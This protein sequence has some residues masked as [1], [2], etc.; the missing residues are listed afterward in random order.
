MGLRFEEDKPPDCRYCYFWK[1][2]K[3]CCS[4][5][6]EEHCYYLLPEEDQVNKETMGTDWEQLYKR[7]VDVRISGIFYHGDRRHLLCIG[8]FPDGSGEYPLGAVLRGGLHG[9]PMLFPDEDRLHQ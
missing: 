3:K 8:K 4:F 1:P 2:Q 5:G 9:T 7:V 6:G